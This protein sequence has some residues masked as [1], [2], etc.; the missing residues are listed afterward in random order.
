MKICNSLIVV[1]FPVDIYTHI[2]ASHPSTL[3]IIFLFVMG[4]SREKRATFS[5]L[6]GQ[7]VR[8]DTQGKR[9]KYCGPNNRI[10]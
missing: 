10:N 6:T 8:H 7:I 5:N 4:K 2:Y 1:D 3:R 9:K